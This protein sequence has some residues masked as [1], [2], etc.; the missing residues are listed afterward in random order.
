MSKVAPCFLVIWLVGLPASMSPDQ[1]TQPYTGESLLRDCNIAVK[2]IDE[3]QSAALDRMST[4]LC[5]GY[6]AGFLDGFGQGLTSGARGEQAICPP[7]EHF[8]MN[9]VARVVSK[10]LR[11]H[12]ERLH[13]FADHLV[14]DS[15]HEAFPCI[16]DGQRRMKEK[17]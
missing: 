2:S 13:Q 11:D 4:G 12:P 1:Q 6:L 16:G 8:N 17:N 9:Q 15:M 5:L 10:F 3:D 14:L 7:A